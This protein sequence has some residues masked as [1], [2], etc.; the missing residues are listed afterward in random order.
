MSW[1]GWL[2]NILE[3]PRL[4]YYFGIFLLISAVRWSHYS[5]FLNVTIVD[6][7]ITFFS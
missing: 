5:Y 1:G 7:F 3:L 4:H 2:F 6:I